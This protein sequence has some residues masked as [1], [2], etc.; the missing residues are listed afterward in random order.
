[1]HHISKRKYIHLENKEES[2]QKTLIQFVCILHTC[3][4]HSRWL[5]PIDV[6]EYGYIHIIIRASF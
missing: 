1:M 6:I 3:I 2:K 5:N 4:S